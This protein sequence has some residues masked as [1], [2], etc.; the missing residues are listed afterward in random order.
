MCH[1]IF[2]GINP[3]VSKHHAFHLLLRDMVAAQTNFLRRIFCVSLCQ[4]LVEA[5]R[6]GSSQTPSTAKTVT[7]SSC[8]NKCAHQRRSIADQLEVQQGTV[9]SVTQGHHTGCIISFKGTYRSC[10]WL[11]ESFDLGSLC[12]LT[13]GGKKHRLAG[14]L[15]PLRLIAQNSV[16]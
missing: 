8:R 15:K 12:W 11:L 2:F 6:A 3:R 1:C 5:G 13:F 14:N 16:P 9:A 7:S 4:L 10:Q